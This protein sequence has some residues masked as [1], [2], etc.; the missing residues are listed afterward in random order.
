MVTHEWWSHHRSK[1]DLAVSPVVE[2]EIGLGDARTAQK[3][4]ALIKGIRLLAVTPEVDRLAEIL[5]AKGPLPKSA[6][7]D[8]LHI[9]LAAVHNIEYLLSW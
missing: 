7:V 6:D 9:S 8:A 2:K 5:I 3:R 4:L 1:Y